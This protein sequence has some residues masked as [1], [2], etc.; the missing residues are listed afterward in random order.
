MT[1]SNPSDRYMSRVTIRDLT[2]PDPKSLL[3][4]SLYIVNWSTLSS[5][6]WVL[7]SSWH[8]SGLTVNVEQSLL[9]LRSELVRLATISQFQLFPC[10][11]SVSWCHNF[12]PPYMKLNPANWV[13]VHLAANLSAVHTVIWAQNF[14]SDL[15]LLIHK[16]GIW[17]SIPTTLVDKCLS[18]IDSNAE[19]TA[20]FAI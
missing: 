14:V 16:F 2:W 6:V 3:G 15:L 5:L 13:L 1:D 7:V 11:I 19:I 17:S 9:F 20:V 10:Q 4:S 12:C 18:R 8:S